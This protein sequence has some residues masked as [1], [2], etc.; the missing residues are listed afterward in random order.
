MDTVELIDVI[1]TLI[2]G[3]IWLVNIPDS[4]SDS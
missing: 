1:L 3:F 4:D 2:V